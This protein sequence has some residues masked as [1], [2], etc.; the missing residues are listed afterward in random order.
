MRLDSTLDARVSRVADI[1]RRMHAGRYDYNAALTHPRTIDGL[2]R[3]IN[4]PPVTLA[5]DAHLSDVAQQRSID[6]NELGRQMREYHGPPSTQYDPERRFTP[7][8]EP[9][10]ET[11]ARMV[12]EAVD[13]DDRVE[14]AER[15]E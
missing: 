11:E 2:M 10:N 12:L 3:D 1:R 14:H 9:P 7:K 13:P 5:D 6:W 4:K 15:W 8:R